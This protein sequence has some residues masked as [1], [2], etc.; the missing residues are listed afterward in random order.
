MTTHPDWWDEA[1]P[2]I[3]EILS[4]FTQELADRLSA[5]S[6]NIIR[7]KN[8][9][10]F[11]MRT[12][13]DASQFADTAITAY[14]SSSEETKFGKV[15][16]RIAVVTCRKGRNGRESGITNVD[17]EYD[18]GATRTV[19][20][21]KSGPRWGNAD[22]RRA[23]ARNFNST[24]AVLRQNGLTPICVE[25]ICYGKSGI[26]D[27]GTHVRITGDAFWEEISGSPR[28]GLSIM[29]LIGEHAGNGL[30]ERRA[31][32]K[33]AMVRYLHESEIAVNGEMQWDRLL[34]L[35]MA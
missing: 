2:E 8:P 5:P 17:L 4:V 21:V 23:L 3:D 28:T 32:A 27:L 1:R 34:E 7:N 29:Q 20:Q 15:L 26:R 6:R 10:L 31:A 16:E 24:S 9:F 22:A 18:E 30:Y 14:L 11:R 33:V 25:G 19:V 12:N 13:E 35:V